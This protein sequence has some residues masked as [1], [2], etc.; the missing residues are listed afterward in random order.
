MNIK[1]SAVPIVL[2]LVSILLIAT[3]S[4]RAYQPRSTCLPIAFGETVYGNITASTNAVTYCFYGVRGDTINI[5]MFTT[6]GDLDGYLGLLYRPTDEVLV[7]VDDSIGTDPTLSN[8]TLPYDGEYVIIATR[9]DLGTGSTTGSYELTL[10]MRAIPTAPIGDNVSVTCHDGP[11]IVNGAEIVVVQMR[12]GFIYKATAVGL[13]GFDPI[14]AILDSYGDGLCSDD[15]SPAEDY[16]LLLPTTGAVWGQPTSAQ[17][18]FEQNA[19][20]VFDDVSLVVG[21]YEGSGGEFVLI[22]EGMAFTSADNLG[23]PFSIVLSPAIVDYG[24]PITAY[25]IGENNSIDPLIMTVSDDMDYHLTD[26]LNSLIECDDAGS[27]CWGISEDLSGYYVERNNGRRVRA[28]NLDAML[29]VPLDYIPYS[30]LRFVMSS[31]EARSTGN[32]IVVFHM[33]IAQ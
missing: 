29:M 26:D 17:I 27:L 11:D 10:S 7:E 33:G 31:Y 8:Y 2:A 18:T 15:D 24:L 1:K 6:S 28:D 21:G 16:S 19:D 32:Y 22:L 13:Y 30:E 4:L 20:T 23:D 14:L 5:A 25:M 3:S 12:S 9:Y